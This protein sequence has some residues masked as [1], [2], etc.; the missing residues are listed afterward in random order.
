M[1]RREYRAE[2]KSLGGQR[3]SAVAL[4]VGAAK[5]RTHS[6]KQSFCLVIL[7][8]GCL[9]ASQ[10]RGEMRFHRL[11]DLSLSLATLNTSSWLG[12]GGGFSCG[13]PRAGVLHPAAQLLTRVSGSLKHPLS[14]VRSG[15]GLGYRTLWRG[16]EE[17][18]GQ[19]VPGLGLEETIWG[20]LPSVLNCSSYPRCVPGRWLGSWACYH[21]P[22]WARLAL[23]MHKP[24]GAYHL[25]VSLPFWIHHPRPW[26]SPPTFLV[27]LSAIPSLAQTPRI[28]GALWLASCCCSYSPP[29]LPLRYSRECSFWST[30]LVLSLSCLEGFL[31]IWR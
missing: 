30:D 25:S 24:T 19:L 3:S 8:E 14:S 16:L 26:R 9:Q 5:A 11:C 28:S 1:E 6:G 21:F 7:K 23:R 12:W 31:L 10:G 13:N 15:P 2:T 29:F 17:M 20:L 4:T 27:N 22:Q 18:Y